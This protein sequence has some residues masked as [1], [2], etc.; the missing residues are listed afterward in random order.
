MPLRMPPE[1]MLAAPLNRPIPVTW[2]AE[3]KWDGYR[4]LVAHRHGG[5]VEI[6]SRRGTD[7]TKA[8]PEIASAA[9]RDLPAD[10]LLDGEL[11]IWQEG[12][13]AFELLGRRLNR[14]P[15]AA[16]RLSTDT[17][18]HFVAFDV[19]YLRGM[20]WMRSPYTERRQVLG[21]LFRE[22]RLAP[23][24]TLCPTAAADDLDT[25]RTW[26]SWAPAGIEGIVAKNPAQRYLPGRRAWG[27][28][29][30]RSSSE[31]IPA[32]VTGTR[33][34]P[35][36]VLLGRYDLAHRLRYT[37]RTTPLPPA[38][39]TELAPLLAPAAG[40]HP[41]TGRRFSA[42]WGT[43]DLLDVTLVDPQLVAEVSA[44]VALDAAGRW[45]HPVRWLRLRPDL[46]PADVPL[47]DTPAET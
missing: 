40:E 31:A 12:R 34:N 25:I 36:S 15:A 8:F 16:M 41:W 20:N 35:S 43:K 30:V 42:G 27:K 7:M 33:R 28:L 24:W 14:T 19:L 26:L 9:W 2:R 38:A 11:V 22:R 10:T 45:R 46:A 6:R 37:G 5:A 39:R 21:S 44:D 29:R 3:P 32:A 13:L 17:P 23:P 1:P 18:A 47:F 4:A